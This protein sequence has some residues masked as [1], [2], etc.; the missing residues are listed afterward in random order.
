MSETFGSKMR[1]LATKLNATFSGELPKTDIVTVSKAYNP[2]TGK[3]TETLTTK[4]AVVTF[5]T[6]SSKEKLDMS[7]EKVDAKAY[8]AGSE[9]DEPMALGT[10][11]VNVVKGKYKVVSFSFD[12]YDANCTLF[13]IQK[14]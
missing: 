6:L 11:L 3:N 2:H 8:V 4:S 1:S 13:L 12:Q 10:R 5:V 14:K 7:A 9:L